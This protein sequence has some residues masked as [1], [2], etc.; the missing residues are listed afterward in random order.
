MRN[1]SDKDWLELGKHDPYFGVMTNNKFHRANLNE[2]A[3]SEFFESGKRDIELFLKTIHSQIDPTFKPARSLEFGCGVGRL[4]IPLAAISDNVTGLDV[5]PHMLQEAKRNCAERG[6]TNVQFAVMED[7]L[8]MVAGHFNFILSYIVFQHIPCQRGKMLLRNLIDRLEENGIG[9]VHFTYQTVASRISLFIYR[10]RRSF[11]F[12][13]KILN[14]V[15]SENFNK[16]HMQMNDYNL[17]EI[18]LVV[19]EAGCQNCYLSFTRHGKHL[20]V[21]FYFQKKSREITK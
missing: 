8:S 1:G 13:H 5:S 14:L 6:L 4:I 20:G 16:P 10:L 7:S 12:I 18:L 11:R 19:Q 21:M 3:L 17:N 2:A 9:A 15:W